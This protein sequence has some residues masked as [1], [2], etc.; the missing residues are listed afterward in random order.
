MHSFT[1]DAVIADVERVAIIAGSYIA[2]PLGPG[3]TDLIADAS[4]LQRLAQDDGAR[5]VLIGGV[6]AMTA[7]VNRY[8]GSL[9]KRDCVNVFRAGKM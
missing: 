8:N 5:V 6:G 2:K 4:V 3:E 9:R 1:A 7:T